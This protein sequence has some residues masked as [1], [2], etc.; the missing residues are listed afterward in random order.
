MFDLNGN[1]ITNLIK[2]QVS[3]G[4]TKNYVLLFGAEN[5]V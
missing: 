4:K 3:S 5:R 1:L 2:S